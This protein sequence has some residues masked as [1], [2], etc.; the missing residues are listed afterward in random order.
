M[1]ITR[2]K[3]SMSLKGRVG[4]IT[5]YDSDG[6]QISRAA[7]NSSNYG[8][9]ASRT[10]LQ[11]NRR[12]RWA[13]LVNAYKKSQGW[14][15]YAFEYKKKGVSDYNKFMQLNVNRSF[16]ALTRD[17]AA[18]GACVIDSYQVSEGSLMPI[19]HAL[20]DGVWVTNVKLG[21][22]TID[23]ETT[24]GNFTE[25]VI[26]NNTWIKYDYQISFISYQQTVDEY[27]IPRIICTP[28]ELTLKKDSADKVR[29]YLPAFCSSVHNGFLATNENITLG[30]FCYVLSAKENGRTV[31]STQYLVNNNQSLIAQYTSEEQYS[32]AIKSYGEDPTRF[33]EP[34]SSAT[35]ATQAAY[36]IQYVKVGEKEIYPQMG[37]FVVTL[38]ASMRITVVSSREV[39]SVVI[40]SMD[41][42]FKYRRITLT[43]SEQTPTYQTKIAQIEVS[44]DKFLEI[45]MEPVPEVNFLSMVLTIDGVT[46]SYG[47]GLPDDSSGDGPSGE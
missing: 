10:A 42:Q 38:D 27:G 12:V 41:V 46:Y 16:V 11:Q 44:W 21:D 28:Y 26:Q 31:V 3:V 20:I 45:F 17:E 8:K 5:F 1:A 29:N 34:G 47:N 43:P 30:A 35:D 36:F 19:S 33:L 18:S 37:K 7:R 4:A 39:R 32:A 40:N 22:Y 23:D 24:I 6:R 13:N 9:G 2:S 25:A 14:M 15:Y